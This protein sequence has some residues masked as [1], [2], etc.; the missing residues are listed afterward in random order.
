MLEMLPKEE[1]TDVKGF[2]GVMHKFWG[3]LVYYQRPPTHTFMSSHLASLWRMYP[4]C[5]EVIRTTGS[6]LSIALA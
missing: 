1:G 4:D 5:P 2:V 3:F 6:S